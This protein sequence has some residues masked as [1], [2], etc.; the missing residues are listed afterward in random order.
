[1][2]QSGLNEEMENW[3]CMLCYVIFMNK[4]AKLKARA[5][6]HE[7]FIRLTSFLFLHTYIYNSRP[8]YAKELDHLCHQRLS[9]TTFPCFPPFQFNR[10]IQV[11]EER[12]LQH[13]NPI[14]TTFTQ[15]N[16][17]SFILNWIWRKEGKR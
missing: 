15:N 2:A 4:H 10:P 11:R 7:F 16:F 14:S 3:E 17:S 6:S 5:G 9:S 12:V 13:K 8:V 1:M